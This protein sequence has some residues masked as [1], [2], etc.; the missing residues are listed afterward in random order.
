MLLQT[1]P[2]SGDSRADVFISFFP[3]SF[4]GGLGQEVSSEL[5]KDVLV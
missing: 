1:F 5:S 4:L 2:G 3:Q